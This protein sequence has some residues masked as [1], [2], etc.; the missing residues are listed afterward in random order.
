MNGF[1]A[2]VLVALTVIGTIG[3]SG[4]GPLWTRYVASGYLFVLL[5]VI[6]S[7][8]LNTPTIVDMKKLLGLQAQVEQARAATRD[9]DDD[10]GIAMERRSRRN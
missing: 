7:Q 6:V 2:L 1:K 9:D 4:D 3:F 8:S 5:L 10:D